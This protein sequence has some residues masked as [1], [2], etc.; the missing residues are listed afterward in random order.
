MVSS[1]VAGASRVSQ[2]V[3]NFEA[4]DVIPLITDEVD[5]EMRAIVKA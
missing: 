4:V 5:E 1:V 2:G 3:Q